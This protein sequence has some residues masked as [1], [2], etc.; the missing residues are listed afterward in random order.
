M[1]LKNKSKLSTIALT[2]I[3]AISAILVALPAATAQDTR[4]TYPFLGVVPN[5]V[6][7][8]QTI[9]LH[10]GIFQQLDNVGMGWEGLSITI[11][12]PDNQTDTISNIRTDSTGGTGRTYT[13]DMVGTYKLQS[14]FPQQMTTENKSAPGIP[15]NTTMLASSSAVVELVVQEEPIQYYPGHALPTEYWTRPIDAQL[16]EWNTMTGNWL[17]TATGFAGWRGSKVVSGNSEAPETAHILWAKPLTWGGLAGATDTYT[18]EWA[19]SHGDAYEG[20]W[21]SRWIVNGIVI[22]THRDNTLPLEYTAI[23]IRTGEE[24][25]TKTLLDNRTIFRGQNLVWAGYNHHAIYPYFWVTVGS[26]WYAFDPYT[27]DWEFTVANVPAGNTLVDEQGW[28]YQLNLDFNNGTGYLWSM[29]DLIE[30]F[31]EDSPTPGSWLPGGSFYGVRYATWNASAV[32]NETTG[33]LT[34]AAQRAYIANFTFETPLP[35][36]SMAVR[37]IGFGDR[38]FGLQYGLTEINTWAISLKD[39][40]EGT[41]L[42]NKTWS[43]PAEWEAGGVQIEFET[44]SLVEGAA[45]FWVKDKLAHYAFS[46]DDGEYMW[47]PTETEY[48]MNY[49]GWTELGERPIVLYNGKFYSSGAGGITYCYNLTDGEIIWTYAAEDPYQEFLFANDWW[50]WILFIADGKM[51]LNHL[52]HSAIEPMPRGA[53]FLC[54]DAETGDVIFRADGLFRGM[55]WGGHA[56]IGDSVIVTCDSYDQRVYAIGKGASKTTV[57]IQNDVITQGSSVMIKGRVTDVSPGT[58]DTRI[59]LRFPNGVPAVADEDQ[60]EWMLYVYKQFAAPVVG[61]VDVTLIVEDPTGQ[62][63]Q[64]SVTSDS[65]GVFS[66]MWK[67]GPVGEYHVT[68]VACENSKAYYTSYATTAF[69]VDQAPA[70]TGYQGPS[71]DE[72]AQATVNKLPPYP[73]MPTVPTASEVAQETISRLPAY[74]TVPSATEIAQE[75]ADRIPE[76]AM[77]AYLTIDLIILVIVAIGVV[78]SLLAYMAIRKQ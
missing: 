53:P 62:Y 43:A 28:L 69:G 18:P 45:V 26:D 48:Y 63:Y 19:F 36:G 60:S 1:E 61:G 44:V 14:H 56:I 39:G 46:T 12:R 6:G 7:V 59:K 8:D 41:L 72:I 20:K 15:I 32:A 47:G 10:V 37:A 9:L 40:E 50:E 77:P 67:P 70:D 65:N 21:T 34:E 16:R 11:E 42:F 64:T 29:V 71:A 25:W 22:Y 52:E 68:A 57:S 66:H 13:P 78:I 31:G 75:T 24:L 4:I 76:A 51:Y 35:G 38:V 5:P 2:M 27:G 74:P 17:F 33:E 23:N 49:Y 30:P 55:L 3:L 54:L 58:E 73:T